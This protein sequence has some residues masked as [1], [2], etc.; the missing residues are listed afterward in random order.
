MI[1]S[2]KIYQNI[3]PVNSLM[4]VFKRRRPKLLTQ[5]LAKRI[6][7]NYMSPDSRTINPLLFSPKVEK[8]AAFVLPALNIMTPNHKHAQVKLGKLSSSRIGP[9]SSGASSPMIPSSKKIPKRCNR[10]FSQDL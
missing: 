3:A 8:K 10:I 4:K 9:P 7:R 6:T 2:S 5:G 1:E